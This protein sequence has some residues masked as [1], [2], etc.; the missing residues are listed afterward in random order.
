VKAIIPHGVYYDATEL[1]D[2][3]L[4]CEYPAVLNYPAFRSGAWATQED[5][6]VIPSASPFVYALALFQDAFPSPPH[7]EGTLFIP[8]HTVQTLRTSVKWSAVAEELLA[9]PDEFQPV[10][11]CMYYVDYLK[12]L[13][14]PFERRG[15][16]VVCAGHSRDS[17]YMFRWLHL[18]SRHRHVVSNDV[19]GG[20]LYATKAGKPVTLL[21]DLA[22][23]YHDPQVQLLTGKTRSEQS[24]RT[25]DAIAQLFR[26]HDPETVASRIETVDYLLGCENFK[27]PE[28]LLRDVEYAREL[29]DQ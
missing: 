13:H 2:I 29:A 17:D 20:V 18:L 1:L 7:E 15:M 10:T 21:R 11:V 5:R 19:G 27:T 16:Q 6:V 24:R 14:E 23:S 8:A 12:K 22:Q 4:V 26:S 9:M 3:E 25:T 28:G